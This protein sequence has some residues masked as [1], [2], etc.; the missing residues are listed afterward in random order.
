MIRF[1]AA[2]IC[3]FALYLVAMLLMLWG[4][5]L[6]RQRVIESL[7]SPEALAEWRA[8]AEETRKEPV[9]GQA[10]ERRP[11]K[12]D[13]PPSL[14]LMRDHFVA[15][16]STSLLIGSFV[17]AF[18]AFLVLGSWRARPS[19]RKKPPRAD[20]R[21]ASVALLLPCPA[22]SRSL[23]VPRPGRSTGGHRNFAKAAPAATKN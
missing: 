18:L 1:P 10:V 16:A 6:A 7:G 9:P 19:H 22:V 2:T 15:I 17:Y 13:E 20:R 4:L 5:R 11:V 14:V 3:A 21:P 12:S 8:F 23:A